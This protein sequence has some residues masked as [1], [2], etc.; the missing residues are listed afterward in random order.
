[1][2]AVGLALAIRR[3][4]LRRLDPLRPAGRD[5]DDVLAPAELRRLRA[6]RGTGELATVMREIVTR[7]LGTVEPSLLVR[8]ETFGLHDPGGRLGTLDDPTLLTLIGSESHPLV[9]DPD[10]PDSHLPG[11]GD[12]GRRQLVESGASVATPII[13]RDGSLAGALLLGEP[14]GRRR[15]RSDELRFLRELGTRAAPIVE[16]SIATSLSSLAPKLISL[17]SARECWRCTSVHPAETELCPTCGRP[18]EETSVPH[19]LDGRFQFV[20]RIGTGGMGLVYRARDLWLDRSI[21]IKTLPR[22]NPRQAARL[23][24]EARVLGA[25]SHSHLAV[26]FGFETWHGTPMLLLEYLGAGTLVDRVDDTPLSARET[27][28][29]GIS[30]SGAL[31]RLHASGILHRD[32]K[33]SNIGYT[34]GGIPKLLDFGIARF[35]IEPDEERDPGGGSER[36]APIEIDRLTSTH[37][38]MGTLPYLAPE[39]LAGA[40]PSPMT[41]LWSLAV[42]LWEAHAGRNAIDGTDA[43]EQADLIRQAAIPRLDSVAPECPP[44]LADFF[45]R[46]L[47]REAERRPRSASEFEEE[48]RILGRE[49]RT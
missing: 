12:E 41:D 3:P 17:A 43:T 36:R 8:G 20:E 40:D 28:E 39:I 4:L 46:A 45:A 6:A 27:V 24:R 19:R 15:W 48:L 44:A 13:G 9:L 7:R 23:R 21:A 25:V 29:L 49:V 38:L 2:A 22:V 10:D 32:I 34:A 1:M 5:V 14:D 37:G 35:Q 16:A 11:L 33:P 18:T 47:H 30:L 42:V 26:I 31:A